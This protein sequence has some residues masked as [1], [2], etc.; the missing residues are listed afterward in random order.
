M[1]EEWKNN[2]R[3]TG[4]KHAFVDTKKSLR[5]INPGKV[6]YLL[7]SISL[8]LNIVIKYYYLQ[9]FDNEFTLKR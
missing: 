2:K 9:F 7:G 5:D 4:A 6:D 1:V 3:K 8:A